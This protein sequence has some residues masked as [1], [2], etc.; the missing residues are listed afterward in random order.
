M[1]KN[2]FFVYYI[3]TLRIILLIYLLVCFINIKI[4]KLKKYK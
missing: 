4:N 1:D 3:L 2:N